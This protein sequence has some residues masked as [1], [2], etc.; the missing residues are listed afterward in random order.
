MSRKSSWLSAAV[1]GLAVLMLT[2]CAR[3]NEGLPEPVPQETHAFSNYWA[4]RGYDAMDIIRLQWGVPR[5]FKAIGI[6]AKATA[7]AQVGFVHFA[8]KKVGM[9]RRGLGIM[10]Q[11]K[12]EGGISPLYFTSIRSAGEYGNYFLRANTEWADVR[13]RRIIRNGFFWSD[14]TGRPLSFGVETAL[15]CLG[16][17]DVQIY[18]CE[19]GDF[20]VGWLG[21]DPR[22]D[23]WKRLVHADLD[24]QY[25]KDE[26]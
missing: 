16:G 24:N 15:L 5:D 2:G 17:P 6:T 1:L 22:G 4:N 9:E 23:D 19:L 7:L 25:F 10:R 26:E 14:G 18:L 3:I 8:G 11:K 12:T 13:D 20:F 21:M